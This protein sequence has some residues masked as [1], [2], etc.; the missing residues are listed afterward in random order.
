M[1]TTPTAGPSAGEGWHL[2]PFSDPEDRVPKA[3]VLYD[4]PRPH[5]GWGWRDHILV[6]AEKNE[7][8]PF[9]PFTVDYLREEMRRADDKAAKR[10]KVLGVWPP[11]EVVFEGGEFEVFEVPPYGG[12]PAVAVGHRGYICRIPNGTEHIPLVNP[13]RQPVGRE[14][15]LRKVRPTAGRADL[16]RFLEWRRRRG[17]R[18]RHVPSTYNASPRT[19]N[20]STATAR[21]KAPFA[22][23]KALTGR[24][25]TRTRTP[26]SVAWR[27]VRGCPQASAP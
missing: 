18:L 20:G 21:P 11:P 27:N 7:P 17:A 24:F 5:G 16:A 15:R 10:R 14:V 8:N 3:F 13:G 26:G 9:E 4:D 1:T 23:S 2:R 19:G 25:G 6:R 22:A 12:E